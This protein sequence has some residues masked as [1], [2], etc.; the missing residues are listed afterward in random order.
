MTTFKR[1]NLTVSV[2]LAASLLTFETTGPVFAQTNLTPYSLTE[3]ARTKLFEI[4]KKNTTT[5]TFSKSG[6]TLT[7]SERSNLIATV[8]AAK[9]SG[10]IARVIIAAWSDKDYPAMK[11][12]SLNKKDIE[13]AKARV[14]SIKH[15]LE[16]QG[17]KEIETYTMTENPS[18]FGRL[19]NTDD[20]KIK[21]VGKPTDQE[22]RILDDI[23]NTIRDKGGPGKA[24]VILRQAGE[25]L[26][27]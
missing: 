22:D 10:A 19:F 16:T 23:G 20:T 7:E 5:I 1:R 15:V 2:V 21:G 17:V 14:A 8:N 3:D 24:V 18:W 26:A 4:L 11:G 13:I 25:G 9:N 12:A 6:A 27:H